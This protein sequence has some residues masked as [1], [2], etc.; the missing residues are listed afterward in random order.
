VADNPDLARDFEANQR[1][2]ESSFLAGRETR[3]VFLDALGSA[4]LARSQIL[5]AFDGGLSLLSYVG[6]GGG[7]VWATENMLNITDTAALR[8]QP[9]QPLMLTMNCL[10]GYFIAPSYDSLAEAFLKVAGRGTIGSFSPSGLSLDAPAHLYHRA[11]MA[12]LTSGRHERLGDAVLAAQQAYA[13][14]GAM[15]ELLSIY[16]L[17][18]D[19]ALRIR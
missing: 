4:S 3:R 19:P 7:A 9:R 5:D 14:T 6:H 2:I 11:L 12:E 17:F 15:P 13:E 16:H 8:E 1:E 18:A 10:N